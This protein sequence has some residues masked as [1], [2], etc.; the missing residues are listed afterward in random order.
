MSRYDQRRD[1]RRGHSAAI[2]EYAI[3]K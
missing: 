3:M 1:M 2:P